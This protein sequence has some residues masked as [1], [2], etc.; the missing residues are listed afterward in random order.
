[1]QLDKVTVEVSKPAPEDSDTIEKLV[2]ETTV[3]MDNKKVIKMSTT[4]YPGWTITDRDGGIISVLGL[5]KEVSEV[6]QQPVQQISFDDY[7]SLTNQ[8]TVPVK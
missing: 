4:G 5:A 8:D 2:I 6:S 3:D 7:K 1:M